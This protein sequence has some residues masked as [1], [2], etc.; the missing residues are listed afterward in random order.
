MEI[1]TD[2]QLFALTGKKYR[3]AIRRELDRMGIE[4]HTRSDGTPVV[5]AGAVEK[6]QRPAT[7]PNWGAI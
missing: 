6:Q 1:L 7:G 3:P 2:A 5:T 4:Y